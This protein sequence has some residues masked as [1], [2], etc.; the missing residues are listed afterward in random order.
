MLLPTE[1]PDPHER[2]VTVLAYDWTTQLM[3]SDSRTR[4]LIGVCHQ[5]E[6][7][8]GPVIRLSASPQRAQVFPE[9]GEKATFVGDFAA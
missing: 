5:P 7:G 2:L 6:R 9:N 3:M 4:L 8:P 1:Q